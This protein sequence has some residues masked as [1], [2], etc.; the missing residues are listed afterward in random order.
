MDRLNWLTENLYYLAIPYF[1]LAMAYE[2]VVL[3][4]AKAAHLK[5]Y[6]WR[7]SITSMSLGVFNLV[8]RALFAVVTIYVS[9][10][11]YHYKLLDLSPMLWWT[12]PLLW[13]AEDFT[14]YWYHRASHRIRFMWADHVNHHSSQHY[15]LSTAL[16]QPVIEMAWVWVLWLPLVWIGFHPVAVALMAG[17]NLLYQFWIHT[18]S[19]RSTGIFERFM[20]TPSHHRVH[21]G[22]NPE[23][24]D[25][26][27]GGW[28]IVWDKL[29]GTFTPETVPVRYGLVHNIS[30]FNPFKV[31]THEW[32]YLLRQ[33]WNAK[34]WRNKLAWTFGPPEYTGTEGPPEFGAEAAPAKRSPATSPQSTIAEPAGTRS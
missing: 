34:G 19:V 28:L 3:R 23:Y 11:V 20:N 33:S 29:F 26:N 25:K 7:D 2:I 12:W 32:A 24:I 18:E 15:N 10:A 1:L 6:E 5:G 30:T 8:M 31:V 21:H 27:Y 16:R 9:F 13:L 4:S 22:S 17:L 14:F